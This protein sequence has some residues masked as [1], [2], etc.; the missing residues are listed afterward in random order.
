MID[1]D[2]DQ[3]P[4]EREPSSFRSRN[5]T[6]VAALTA[7]SMLAFSGNS[8]LCRLALKQDRID[9]AS[10]TA[11]RI[12]SGAAAL[13]LIVRWRTGS[14][15]AGGDWF[16]ATALFVYAATFSFAYVGLTAATGA[17]LLF[18]AVQLTM[19][20]W[21]LRLGERPRPL[22]TAGLCAACG[23]LVA[24]LLPNANAPALRE[25]ILM[26]CAGVAW[27]IYSLKGRR[28]TSPLIATTGNFLRASALAIVLSL[29]FV[30]QIHLDA[31]G[32]AYAMASG[33][34]ASGVGYA[35]WYSAVRGLAATTA[36]S[37]QLTVPVIAAL[38]AVVL[39]GEPLSWRLVITS[40]VVLGGV[41]LALFRKTPA[42]ITTD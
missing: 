42:P 25:S 19:I 34:I 31:T 2:Q 5:S 20:G 23:G 3:A 30:S 36:A 14:R 12:V 1:D 16:S 40:L 32:L 27:G 33:S 4:A 28:S 8:L 39:L 41:A 22:Q 35:V 29:V 6:G 21:G 15:P 7:L 17:L 26:L 24:L 10:F 11:V 13:M 38:G 9:A 37:V 18:G